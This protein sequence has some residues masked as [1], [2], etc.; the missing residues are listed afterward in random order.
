M[1]DRVT[2]S[3]SDL[4]RRL[5]VAGALVAL[6]AAALWAGG[7]GFWIVCATAGVLMMGEWADLEHVPHRTKRIA[8][9]S[10]SV[11]LAIMAPIAAGPNFF[12]LGLIIGAAFFVAIITRRGVLALGV[13]Y[14][15]IPILA[16]LLLRDQPSGLLLAFWAMALVWACDSGA[17]FA[18]RAIG[19]PRMAPVISPNK[20]W[21]G[22]FG[23]IAAATAFA[24]ALTPLGLPILMV[25]ATPV[26]AA[27]AVFGDLFE[28]WL[29]RRAG[30]KDSGSLL[31]GHGGV[32][33]R[34][35]GLV[36]V[37]PVAALI[38]L[39]PGVLR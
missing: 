28:S 21:A 1:S 18:G 23:G 32:L 5:V 15:A 26:L 39:A 9:Y 3:T 6:A 16:L 36:P 25:A 20:T 2:G 30:V 10:V 4:N 22:F 35:D 27:L 13:P 11:P 24:F 37:A 8:Q 7:I 31:P 34:I 14:V 38:V 19:G 12:A 17:Y 33:D 29:K